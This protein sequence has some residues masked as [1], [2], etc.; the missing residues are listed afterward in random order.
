[1]ESAGYKQAWTKPDTLE[2]LNARIHDGVP[3][4]E[5]R[6]RAENRRDACF[7][8]LFPY[9]APTAGAKV[10]ELGQGVGWIMEAMLD[11]FPI[12]EIV[13]LDISEVMQQRAADRWSDPRTR[14][15]LYHGL[16]V[17]LDDDTFDNVYSVACIQHIEKHH[18]FLVMKELQRILKPGGHA[19]LEL[20]SVHHKPRRVTW[21]QEAW[22]HINNSASH[23]HHYYSY[24]ELF[25]LFSRE[26]AVTDLDI[27][28]YRMSFWVHFSKGTEQQFHDDAVAQEYFVNR[29]L[30]ASV[31]VPS[32]RS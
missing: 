12:S 28:F 22:R 4:G 9:A 19:T 16:S 23:W 6:E 14:Y 8:L 20:L 29:S 31:F 26:L 7:Q 13:G 18:A 10:L 21:E 11:A 24:D 5:L 2:R 25:V 15:V 17:P 1:M 30:P 27:K 32:R 3:V